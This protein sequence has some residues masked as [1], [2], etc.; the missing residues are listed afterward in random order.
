[1]GN[2]YATSSPQPPTPPPG[3]PS[4]K[5]DKTGTDDASIENP[6]PLEELHRKCKG[7]PDTSLQV[8]IIQIEILRLSFLQSIYVIS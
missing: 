1:M 2:V 6:G 8:P 4:F 5:T 7:T 3:V